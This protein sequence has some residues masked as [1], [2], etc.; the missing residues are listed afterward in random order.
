MLST[1]TYDNLSLIL[2]R[3]IQTRFTPGTVLF[4]FIRFMG[5]PKRAAITRIFYIDDVNALLIK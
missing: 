1:T 2:G 4:F 5:K 3:Q